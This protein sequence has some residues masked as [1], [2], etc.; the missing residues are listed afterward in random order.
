MTF[1]DSMFDIN[2]DITNNDFFSRTAELIRSRGHVIA[3][4][5]FVVDGL[6][7]SAKLLHHVFSERR[8]PNEEDEA[9]G[10]SGED[11]TKSCTQ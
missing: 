8:I 3:S 9:E 2:L 6:I 1:D 4:A 10:V 11:A 7:V 5:P